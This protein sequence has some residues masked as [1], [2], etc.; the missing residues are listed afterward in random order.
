LKLKKVK[1]AIFSIVVGVTT[2]LFIGFYFLN[3]YQNFDENSYLYLRADQWIGL[4]PLL[5]FIFGSI[6]Y[7]TSYF[8]N[9]STRLK[10][11]A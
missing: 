4:L 8:I 10:H 1:S 5:T 6:A 2:T 11:D 7:V 3:S 9:N